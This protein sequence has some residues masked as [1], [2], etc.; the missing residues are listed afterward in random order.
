MD[1]SLQPRTAASM[2]RRGP[3]A[4]FWWAA[5]IGSTG[6]WITIFA[7]IGV[8]DEIGGGGGIL[9][10][11]LS[12]VLPGLI[13]GPFVGA[14][15]DR[16]DRRRLIVIA[17]L[18][19]AA[20]VPFFVFASTLP[21]LVAITIVLEIL[22]LLGQAPRAAV[23]PSMVRDENIVTANSLM[24]GAA[25]GTIPLGAAFNFVL[26]LFPALIIGDIIP[27]ETQDFA[28]AFVFDAFTFLASGL[29]IATLPAFKPAPAAEAEAES[30]Q[31][32]GKDTLRSIV[33]GLS[34]LWRERG[35]RRVIVGMTTA[36][37]GGGT[38][39]I[40][41][42]PFV[43]DVLRA[44]STGF[45]AIVTSL[46]AG[47]AI[48]IA[49]V[50][51]YSSRLLRRDIVFALSVTIT[52]MA[53]SLAAMVNTV[54]GAAAWIF[55]MGLGAGAAYVM[56][57]TH[58]HEHVEDDMRG[59]VFA[60]LFSMMRIGLFVSMALA[61]PLTSVFDGS[62]FERLNDPNRLVLF[63][64]GAIMIISGMGLLWSLRTLFTRPKLES[65]T[66][67]LIAAAEKSR[68]AQQKRK[69][70]WTE[71]KMRELEEDEV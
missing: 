21:M 7:T 1:E 12:R 30:A 6:D 13:V 65:A 22:S 16:F 70:G 2:V 48:G 41:G 28:L 40:I 27:L 46:G 50:S 66:H 4:R 25:Y 63:F 58:L 34:Y 23:I 35:V 49:A 31:L 20:V 68:H 33:E 47:G 8:A 39:I 62:A 56:G 60:T 55:L 53:L 3:F 15:T 42:K 24:L 43:E 9:V 29:I 37:F 32:T 45:F 10:A 71:P 14:I 11:L 64:G 59:R 38:V 69:A 61:V 54:G 19:R 17:D 51:L 44:D 26:A 57:L 18:G 52:G 36:L 67:D 5:A